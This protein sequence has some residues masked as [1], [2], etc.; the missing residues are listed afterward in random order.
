MLQVVDNRSVENADNRKMHN[1][2]TA[3]TSEIQGKRVL[4]TTTETHSR[5]VAESAEEPSTLDVEF[6]FFSPEEMKQNGV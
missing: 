2:T 1:A 3:Q 6:F 5:S 4:L